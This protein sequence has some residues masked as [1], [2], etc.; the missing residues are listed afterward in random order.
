MLHEL[1]HGWQQAHGTPGR[2]N[3][4]NH[5]F[6]NKAL[7]YGLVVD[8]RG[9]TRYLPDSPFVRLLRAYGVEVS[10][11]RAATPPRERERGESKL[12]KWSCGCTNVRC[13]VPDLRAVCLKCGQ[14]FRWTR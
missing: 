14:P 2:R 12:K 11:L 7:T 6:R 4:H 13:A 5:E 1:F 10:P 3:Y 8:E 9:C